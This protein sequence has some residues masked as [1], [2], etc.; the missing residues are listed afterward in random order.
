MGLAG[1]SASDFTV[2]PLSNV[3]L[4]VLDRLEDHN[5]KK[6]LD[7]GLCATVNSDDP[8]YFGGY[9]EENFL[10]V[11]KA[12]NLERAELHGL[13]RNAFEASFLTADAKAKLL[14]ELDEYVVSASVT[15]MI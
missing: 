12:L 8:A 7:A 11:Q 9:I 15:T 1:R 4:R 14:V 10:G 2:W 5:L 13:A 3:K 6:L